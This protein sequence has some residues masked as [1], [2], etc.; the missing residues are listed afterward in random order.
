MGQQG[1]QVSEA[2]TT[3]NYA[4][5]IHRHTNPI[6]YFFHI[7]SLYWILDSGEKKHMTYGYSILFNV[8]PLS[9][10]VNVNLPNSHRVRVYEIGSFH[11]LPDLV[12]I[13]VLYAMILDL[14]FYLFITSPDPLIVSYSLLLLLQF[15]RPLQ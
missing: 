13:N 7:N 6:S 5:I 12:L 10:P 14:T 1:E 15:Y 8:R 11:V 2:N 9:N 4:G 3:A